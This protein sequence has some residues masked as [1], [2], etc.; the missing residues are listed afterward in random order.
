MMIKPMRGEIY[1]IKLDPTVGSEI[2]KKRPAMIIS[3]DQANSTSPR[4]IIAPITSKATSIFPFE[5]AITLNGRSGKILLDQISSIDK[6]RISTKIDY[7]CDDQI[8]DLLAEALRVA[9]GLPLLH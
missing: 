5:V 9:L 1:W 3:N 8:L 7:L 4:V 6:V 2:R